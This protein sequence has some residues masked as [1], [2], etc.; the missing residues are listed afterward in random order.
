MWAN[1]SLSPC[2]PRVD[3]SFR[4][5]YLGETSQALKY[6]GYLGQT[7]PGAAWSWVLL[8]GVITDCSV[9]VG[10]CGQAL[11]TRKESIDFHGDGKI[12]A[13]LPPQPPIQLLLCKIGMSPVPAA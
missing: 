6:I 9:A 10:E 3:L 12:M 13:S 2:I 4:V 7:G 8:P 11:I 1:S 5:I